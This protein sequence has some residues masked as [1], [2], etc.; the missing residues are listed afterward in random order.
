MRIFGDSQEL[1]L[2]KNIV[3]NQA[4]VTYLTLNSKEQKQYYKELLKLMDKNDIEYLITQH[5][6]RKKE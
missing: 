2:F 5:K 3:V 4:I 6:K 1:F